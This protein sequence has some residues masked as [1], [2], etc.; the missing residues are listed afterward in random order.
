MY[1]VMIHCLVRVPRQQSR[2]RSIISIISPLIMK[3]DNEIDNWDVRMMIDASKVT[4]RSKIY[5]VFYYGRDNYI[6]EYSIKSEN[7]FS[8]DEVNYTGDVCE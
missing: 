1:T 2:V 7:A 6:G 3:D 4:E 8:V 5:L